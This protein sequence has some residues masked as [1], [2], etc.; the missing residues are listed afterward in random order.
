MAQQKT[1]ITLARFFGACD[2]D[3]GTNTDLTKARGECGMITTLVNVF[4][5]TNKDNIVVK[6]QIIE[7]GPYYQQLTARLAA[8]DVPNVA[9]MHTS[10]IGDFARIVEPLDDAF[11]SVGIDV[12][13]FTPH[14][15]T[16]VTVGGKVSALPWD[17]H[18]WLWHVNVNMFKK[19]G[20][21]DG[22]GQPIIPK[23]VDEMM[24]QAAKIKEA[25]GK[26]YFTMGTLSSGDAGNGARTF[27]TLLYTQGGNLF[28]NGPEKPD[29]GTPEAKK[30]FEVIE[31]L[32]KSGAITKGLDGAAALGAFLNGDAAVMLTGTWRIDDFVAA[33]GKADSP[34]KDGYAARIFP[35]LFKEEVVW[36]DNHSWVLL[37][38]GND[39]KTRKASLTFMKFLWDNNH[40]WAR[41]GG[42]LPVRQSAMAEY[43]KLPQR[44]NVVKI[45]EIGRAMPKEV[46]RQFGF[47]SII[48]EE[49]NNII[50]GGKP[51]AKAASDA[52]ERADQ[53]LKNR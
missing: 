16:G 18:S 34:L 19:A 50:N 41:G 52:Q 14:A 24:A 31:T 9:V 37:R 22:N 20:L 40:N 3:Y 25:T 17:T 38:G 46:R 30:A 43:A 1:E 29:F 36:A 53:L 39:E 44:A 7:W 13:D 4:N 11:K 12:N 35:N 21:V 47:Q 8:R 48:G 2:A 49:I 32:T 27:Y 42:H 28:A 26:P 51:A 33:S 23:T 5:A 6:P 10:Q 15:K 45:S